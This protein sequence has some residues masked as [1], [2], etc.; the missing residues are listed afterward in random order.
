MDFV[1]NVYGLGRDVILFSRENFYNVVVD[2]MTVRVYPNFG[3]MMPQRRVDFCLSLDGSGSLNRLNR[4]YSQGWGAL[5][6]WRTPQ[7]PT[8]CIPIGE[9]LTYRTNQLHLCFERDGEWPALKG[10]LPSEDVDRIR[11]ALVDAPRVLHSRHSNQGHRLV[12]VLDEM[13]VQ[14]P[15][16]FARYRGR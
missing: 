13:R 11:N 2:H 6:P 8:V 1:A 7:K 16:A 10:W 12:E 15:E 9:D 14:Q 5:I 4:A 3:G